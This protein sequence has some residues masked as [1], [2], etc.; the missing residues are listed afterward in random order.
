MRGCHALAVN[1]GSSQHRA[2]LFSYVGRTWVSWLVYP[3]LA[4]ARQANAADTAP[5]LFL[6]FLSE[7]NTPTPQITDRGVEL[8]AH[9]IELVTGLLRGMHRH[10]GRREPENEPT[11]TGVHVRLTQH[12]GEK[13]TV[14]F[15]VGAK[16][17]DVAAIDHPAQ[18]R[19]AANKCAADTADT[20]SAVSARCKSRRRAAG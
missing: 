16:Q 12:V 8:I 3:D 20:V 9:E 5:S 13:S 6:D 15:G 19:A 1:S 7:L 10:L 11:A 18:R 4:A 17:D 2:S 14:C